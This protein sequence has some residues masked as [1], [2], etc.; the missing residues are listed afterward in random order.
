MGEETISMTK[1]LIGR[2]YLRL[3]FDFNKAKAE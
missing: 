1:D 3:V 2:R